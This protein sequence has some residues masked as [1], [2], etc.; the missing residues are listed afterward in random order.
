MKE[1]F[2]NKYVAWGITLFCVLA[3]LLL[4]FF[5]IY[6]SH[7]ILSFIKTIF[8]ILMPFIYGLAIAYLMNPVVIFFEKKVYYSLLSKILKKKKERSKVV[9]VFSL[10]TSTVVF[11]GILIA[12]I[13]FLIPE[14]LKSLQM[15]VTN[16]NIYLSNSK[17]LLI[18]LFGGTEEMRIFIND[19]Y[20]RFTTFMNDWLDLY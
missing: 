7:Y 15:L 3:A 14:I 5:A 6:R 18:R 1:K 20:A 10:C 13:S 2:D 16:I 12:C 11:V 9:R 8:T 4:L 19:N 17:E